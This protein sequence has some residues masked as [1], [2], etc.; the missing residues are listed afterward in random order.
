MKTLFFGLA[1]LIGASAANA[2]PDV[3]YGN[4]IVAYYGNDCTNPVAI[5]PVGSPYV[6]CDSIPGYNSYVYSIRAAGT[7]A[8]IQTGST[9]GQ[10]I[11]KT[12]NNR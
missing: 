2:S 11:C 1:L 6:N 9:S 5:I 12:Y 4:L 10:V 3:I 7:D 8:C